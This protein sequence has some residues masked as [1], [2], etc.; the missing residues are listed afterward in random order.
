MGAGDF[1]WCWYMYIDVRTYITIQ[2]IAVSC[3]CSRFYL[4]VGH[5]P[6]SASD[7]TATADL[8]EPLGSVVSAEDAVRLAASRP[9]PGARLPQPSSAKKCGVRGG[10]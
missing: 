5:A 3:A 8:S 9:H 10:L 1:A 7:A 6:A 4:I 2:Y